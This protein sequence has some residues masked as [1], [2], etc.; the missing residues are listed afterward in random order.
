MRRVLLGF[1]FAFL[2]V[3]TALAALSFPALTGRVVDEANVLTLVTHAMLDAEL[4]AYEQKTS[5]QVVVVTLKSLQGTTIEDYGYQLGRAWG[6]GQKG[7]NNGVLLIVAPNERKV[8]IEVGYGLEGVLTDA[9]SSTI[10]QNII[11][12]DFRNG[13]LDNGIAKGTEAILATL[14]GNPPDTVKQLP[15]VA[16]TPLSSFNA[17]HSFSFKGMLCVAFIIFFIALS[18]TYVE[19]A[20]DKPRR[21]S[22]GFISDFFYNLFTVLRI[23]LDILVMFSSNSRG[24]GGSRGGS[25]FSGGGGSFG[26]GGASGGW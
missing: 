4:A 19:H 13:Q 14:G 25:G 9:L 8:R 18:M 1:A 3:S 7:V 26:G 12:P 22:N 11:L 17:Q 5:N 21:Q 15:I 6:I 20:G 2:F 24:G 23:I 10:I 16:H